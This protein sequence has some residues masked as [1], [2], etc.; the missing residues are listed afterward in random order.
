MAATVGL[1]AGK[2][3]CI[4]GS[5]SQ[6]T[7]VLPPRSAAGTSKANKLHFTLQGGRLLLTNVTL[8]G[9]LQGPQLGG[10][11]VVIMGSN[12]SDSSSGKPQG[13]KSLLV[14]DRVTFSRVSPRAV[15]N[16]EDPTAILSLKDTSFLNNSHASSIDCSQIRVRRRGNNRGVAAGE[17]PSSIP[18]IS[19][20][21]MTVC[22]TWKDEVGAAG[23]TTVSNA[24]F[25]GTTRFIGNE[26]GALQ[27]RWLT[28]ELGTM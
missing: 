7:I 4:I 18:S 27:T 6:P 13:P 8:S 28:V 24:S 22:Y 5:A 12:S 14:T 26:W 21:F 2:T 25:S 16:T 17:R 10:G 23:L 15:A 19:M 1:A 20:G 11:G 9:H 3:L